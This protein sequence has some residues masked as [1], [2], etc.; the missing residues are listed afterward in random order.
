MKKKHNACKNQFI[1][2]ERKKKL[3]VSAH[4]LV[5]R[6]LLEGFMQKHLKKKKF[7]K[8]LELF[9]AVFVDRN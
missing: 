2:P 4:T 8:E 5:E 7:C 9:K 3:A 1:T 6:D